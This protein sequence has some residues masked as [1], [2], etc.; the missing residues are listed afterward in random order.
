MLLVEKKVRA[1]RGRQS[2]VPVEG[3]SLSFNTIEKWLHMFREQFRNPD[4]AVALSREG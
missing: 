2:L 1:L 4:L 3:I